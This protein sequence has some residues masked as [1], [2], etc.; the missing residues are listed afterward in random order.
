MDNL[1][2]SGEHSLHDPKEIK[3]GMIAVPKVWTPIVSI[4]QYIQDFL[5]NKGSG[6]SVG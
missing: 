5:N 4:A 3:Y 6:S 2:N 1:Q